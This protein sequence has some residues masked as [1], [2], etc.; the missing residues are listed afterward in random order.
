MAVQGLGPWCLW[1]KAEK[2]F[3]GCEQTTLSL[4]LWK[5]RDTPEVK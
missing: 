1:C 4:N 3:L 5:L 2:L